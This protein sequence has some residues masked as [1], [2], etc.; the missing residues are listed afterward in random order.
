LLFQHAPKKM[1]PGTNGDGRGVCVSAE[2][3]R[4]DSVGHDG[5]KIW[6]SQLGLL[7]NVCNKLSSNH[8]R[9]GVWWT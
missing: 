1:V 8:L 5:M 9:L 3:S 7:H 6:Q 4:H 2:H